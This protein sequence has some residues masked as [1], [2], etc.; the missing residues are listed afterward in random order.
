MEYLITMTP[1]VPDGTRA[2]AL[3]DVR[4]RELAA[5]GRVLQERIEADRG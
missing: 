3:D 4:T 5:P 1:H 2:E